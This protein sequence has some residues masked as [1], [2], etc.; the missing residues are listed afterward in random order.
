MVSLSSG[1]MTNIANFA[2][3]LTGSYEISFDDG[4]FWD[5]VLEIEDNLF[6]IDIL[7]TKN[8]LRVYISDLGAWLRAT[9][10]SSSHCW[11]RS[12]EFD[13]PQQFDFGYDI[14]S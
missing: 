7:E 8:Q 10:A 13:F 11:I 14:F 6:E 12:F 4:P 9:Q 1:L 5:S 2:S 3:R